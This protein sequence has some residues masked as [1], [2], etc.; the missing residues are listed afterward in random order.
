MR[1]TATVSISWRTVWI[2]LP[3]GRS[4]TSGSV[5]FG[6]GT[7]WLVLGVAL[8]VCVP[9]R[10]GGGGT[11]GAGEL[12]GAPRFVGTGGGGGT[13]GAGELA[14]APRF[15]GTGGGGGTLGGSG[16]CGLLGAMPDALRFVCGT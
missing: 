6:G 16:A 14:G 5:G 3:V 10:G 2:L 1:G 8:C 15:V 7:P 12:A 13:L 9:G 11:L 4:E